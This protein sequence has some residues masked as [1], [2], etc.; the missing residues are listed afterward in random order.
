MYNLTFTNKFHLNYIVTKY[1]F[2]M[3]PIPIAKYISLYIQ[4]E[5]YN[6]NIPKLVLL[7]VHWFPSLFLLVG[8]TTRYNKLIGGYGVCTTN[9]V[10]EAP[11]H[12][13]HLQK[14]QICNFR[15]YSIAII[16]LGLK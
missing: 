15:N 1:V 5:L 11:P 10:K 3:F 7:K 14:A 4:K 8:A 13:F 2:F 12:L 6:T 16:T 9:V